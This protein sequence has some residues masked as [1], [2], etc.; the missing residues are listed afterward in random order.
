MRHM[1]GAHA[2]KKCRF[3]VLASGCLNAQGALAEI[4]QQL[5]LFLNR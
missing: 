5:E 3:Q 2:L 1:R 4:F